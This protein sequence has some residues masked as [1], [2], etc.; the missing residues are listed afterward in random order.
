MIKV[1]YHTDAFDRDKALFYR[2]EVELKRLGFEFINKVLCHP[3]HSIDDLNTVVQAALKEEREH[4]EKGKILKFNVWTERV[5]LE[6]LRRRELQSNSYA[7][8]RKKLV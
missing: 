8:E 7:R 6:E 1:R 4:P 5:T 2:I 3:T